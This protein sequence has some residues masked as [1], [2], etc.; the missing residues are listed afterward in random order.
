MTR[1]TKGYAAPTT[2]VVV[3][4]KVPAGPSAASVADAG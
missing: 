2:I 4:D 3:I 1:L